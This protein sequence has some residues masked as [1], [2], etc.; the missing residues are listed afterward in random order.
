MTI[1]KILKDKLY[2]EYISDLINDK[3]LKL[4][5]FAHHKYTTRLRHSLYVSYCNYIICKFLKLDAKSA[6]RAGLLHD[7]FFYDRKDFDK[8]VY[9]HNHFSAHPKIAL[10]N[11]SQDFEIN[12]KEADIIL[13]HMWPVTFTLPRY[14]ESLIIIMVDKYCAIMELIRR[15]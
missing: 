10:E 12:K 8:N 11:A 3:T 4:E 15:R 2:I 9:K 13:K 1:N 7:F 5:T 6:A 14:R